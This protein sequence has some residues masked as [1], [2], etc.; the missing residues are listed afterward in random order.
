[1]VRTLTGYAILGLIGL[2]ALK[3]LLGAI[4]FAFS[5]LWTLLSFAAVGFVCY[6]ILKIVSPDTARK[7]R[8]RWPAS[9]SLNPESARDKIAVG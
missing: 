2:A 9:V 6:L 7:V 3:L 8:E 1:M 4:G 5:L